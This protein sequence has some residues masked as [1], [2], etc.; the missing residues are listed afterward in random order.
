V[1]RVVAAAAAL[2]L[3]L[4]NLTSSGDAAPLVTLPLLNPLDLAS[5]ALLLALVRWGL[6]PANRE[7]L[8]IPPWL[9]LAGLAAL[10]FVWM[11]AAL[12]R[13]LHYGIG[14]PLFGQGAMESVTL[15]AA[16]SVFWS[17]IA[18]ATMLLA[19]QRGLR[20]VWLAGAALMA[21]VVA[22]L[23][24]VDTAGT[25]TLA[26]IVA[27]FSVGGVVLV[28]GYFSPLPPARAKPVETA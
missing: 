20:P 14:T 15:Q 4:Q 11:S 28:T 7:G 9:L 12:V 26:R 22:K 2:W 23:F 16:L 8:P 6:V 25:G 5:L 19:S 13:G 18:F 17:L 27:F 3:L 21:V 10:A 1:A 24:L